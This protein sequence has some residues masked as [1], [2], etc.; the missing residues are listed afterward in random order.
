VSAALKDDSTWTHVLPAVD[1]GSVQLRA[2][3]TG[4]HPLGFLRLVQTVAPLDVA[5]TKYGS[6]AVV[7]TAP[8]T[9]AI[10]AAGAVVSTATEMFSTSQFF[11]LSD[12]ERLSKPGFVSF[13]AGSTVAGSAWQVF[14]A[15]TVD[16]VYEESL[17]ADDPPSGKRLRGMSLVDAGWARAGATGR[18]HPIPPASLAQRVVVAEPAYAVADAATG[19]TIGAVGPSMVMQA[20]A[21]QSVDR[22][23]VTD[24]ESRAVMT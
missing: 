3:A 23:I 18:R 13:D 19:Q 9:V 21:R 12:E 7:S 10:T 5:L 14:D 1:G 17:G 20:S 16:V 8:V 11:D 2:G 22:V 6:N 4:L 24:Y 15:T